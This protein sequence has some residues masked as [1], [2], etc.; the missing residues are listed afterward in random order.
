L[1]SSKKRVKRIVVGF[2][3]PS[4]T[5][6]YFNA[7]DTFASFVL[8]PMFTF[9]FAV[10][11]T[12]HAVRLL[13]ALFVF[14]ASVA[15]LVLLK[16]SGGSRANVMGLAKMVVV[17]AALLCCHIFYAVYRFLQF[18]PSSNYGFPFYFEYGIVLVGLPAITYTALLFL[19]V[20]AT[21]I[22]RL[23]ESNRYQ[24]LEMESLEKKEPLIPARY[25]V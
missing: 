16:R 17:T 5:T 6:L 24:Q 15:C 9:V 23:K 2:L 11:T 21:R 19:V 12:F 25:E 4:V 10:E 14:G 3:L 7:D 20:E 22:L 1:F 13:L 18:R 8:S